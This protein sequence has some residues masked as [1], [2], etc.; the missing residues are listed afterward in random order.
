MIKLS[1]SI[2]DFFTGEDNESLLEFLT[3][4]PPDVCHSPCHLFI[5]PLLK[6][7]PESPKE[8][9]ML[10]H[11][12]ILYEVIGLGLDDL[13]LRA[14]PILAFYELKFHCQLPRLRT[15]HITLSLCLRKCQCSCLLLQQDFTQSHLWYRTFQCPRAFLIGGGKKGRKLT[16]IELSHSMYHLS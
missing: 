6:I 11:L 15:D 14:L 1:D 3:V 7:K 16:F 10:W 4:Y 9:P 8:S 2:G 13:L 12:R 5:C